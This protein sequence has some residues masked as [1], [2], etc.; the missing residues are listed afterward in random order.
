ML[1]IALLSPKGRLY[2]H[3]SGIFRRSLRYAPLTLPTLVSLVPPEIPHRVTLIDEGIR[4]IPLDLQA[5]IVGITVITPTAPRSW[6]RLPTRP[7]RR[8]S[9]PSRHAATKT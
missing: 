6:P 2:R 9:K 8:P 4:D 3:R 1:S 5:D 7:P